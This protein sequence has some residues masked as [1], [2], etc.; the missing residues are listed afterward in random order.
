MEKWVLRRTHPGVSAITVVTGIKIINIIL[1]LTPHES[2]A[3]KR[4]AMTPQRTAICREG[5][6]K[7]PIHKN[8]Q[9]AGLPAR[10]LAVWAVLSLHNPTWWS[11]TSHGQQELA[12][13][14]EEADTEERLSSSSRSKNV[15]A[16]SKR[17]QL[18]DNSEPGK[19]C[20]QRPLL[21]DSCHRSTQWW[22]HAN[23]RRQIC[24]SD[25]WRAI[26]IESCRGRSLCKIGQHFC[27]C[28]YKCR[29]LEHSSFLWFNLSM[30]FSTSVL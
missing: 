10:G 1:I 15:I 27:A 20:Y 25:W 16:V 19:L 21:S 13:D 6:V 3:L 22:K 18:K 8:L 23:F 9:A 29:H 4:F 2:F 26:S 28:K 30:V 17:L 24:D 7:Y 11:T 5:Q 14:T 12:G